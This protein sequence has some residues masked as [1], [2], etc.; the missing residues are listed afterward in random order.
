MLKYLFQSIPMTI[1]LTLNLPSPLQRLSSPLLESKKITL[2]VKREDLIHPVIGGNKWRKLK[3]NIDTAQQTKAK[4]ILSFGGAYSNHIY[5]LA[6]MGA[7]FGFKTIGVIRGEACEP[8]NSTLSFAEKSGMHLHYVS[9]KNY[10]LKETS[11][12]VDELRSK[13]GEFLLIPEGGSNKLALPG[14]AEIIQEIDAQLDGL[15]DC[16]CLP[17]GTGGTLAGLISSE[18]DKQLLAIAVLKNAGFLSDNVTQLLGSKDHVGWTINLDYHFNGYAKKSLGLLGFINE[19][20]QKFNILLEPVYSGKLFYG[21][22][23]LIKTDYFPAGSVIVA[24]HTG[25]LQSR[26]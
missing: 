11:L 14:C 8:L 4:T 3:Y 10:R 21:L 2:Y 19:F 1:D 18:T 12:F 22:F 23:D 6:G 16:V 15:Y 9:R 13:F 20:E 25:G 5:A 26:T 24:L 17:C 7:M